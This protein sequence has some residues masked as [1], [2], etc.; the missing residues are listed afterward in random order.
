MWPWTRTACRMRGLLAASSKLL[1]TRSTLQNGA[2]ATCG[3]RWGKRGNH[4]GQDHVRQEGRGCTRE[5]HHFGIFK[6]Q[7]L[8]NG[9]SRA[10]G[11]AGRGQGDTCGNH[12]FVIF[13]AQ[14]FQ[15]GDSRAGGAGR[16][17]GDTCG[18]HHF[19]IFKAQILQSRN[20]RAVGGE[21]ARAGITSLAFSRPKSFK[22]V[23]PARGGGGQGARGSRLENLGLQTPILGSKTEVCKPR[24]RLENGGLQSLILGSKMGVCK[25]ALSSKVVI[26]HTGDSPARAGVGRR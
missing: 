26:P 18:N 9:D 17:Q 20:S 6:A 25:P 14:I 10:G 2:S 16:G 3:R 7:I 5:N 12:H 21:G 23:I 13:K 22:M 24:S 1:I 19:G 4:Q 8:Q 11:R 15:N